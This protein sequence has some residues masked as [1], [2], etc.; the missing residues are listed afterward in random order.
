[1]ADLFA[2]PPDDGSVEFVICGCRTYR[3]RETTFRG[4]DAIVV[5]WTETR[6]SLTAVD[7][8]LALATSVSRQ[9]VIGGHYPSQAEALA[10]I[11][12]VEA[13]RADH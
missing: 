3:L 9:G 12:R 10:A 8:R 5:S 1:M 11:D 13:V 7:E 4:D 2:I 6:R